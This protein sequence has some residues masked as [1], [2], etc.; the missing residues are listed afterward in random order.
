MKRIYLDNAGTTATDKEILLQMKKYW[1]SD[2]GN[3]SSMYRSG[4]TASKVLGEARARVAKCLN[5]KAEEIIF[6]GGGTE[7]DNLA[8]L[9]VARA[10]SEFGKHIIISAI[11]HKAVLSSAELLKKEGFE[12]SVVGVDSFGIV[13]VAEVLKMIKKDTILISIMLGN[14]EIGS[15][16]PIE[17]LGKKIKEKKNKSGFPIFH[18]DACQAPVSMKIDVAKLGVG[19]L[20]LNSSKIYGPK[21]AGVLYKKNDIKLQP[22]V[23]GGGQENG[24]RSGT[25]NLP[26]I[27]GMSLALEKVQKNCTKEYSRLKKMREY[28]VKNLKTSIPEII[29]NGHP[30]KVL[31]HIVHVT[32]PKIEGESMLL[33]LDQKGIEVS[34]GSAC[35]AHD[36]YPSHVMVAIGQKTELLHGSI[37]FSFG[38]DT[39]KKDLDFV[40]SVFPKIVE[41]LKNISCI[42]EKK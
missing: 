21:G 4:R 39:T 10:N 18:T 23:V 17:E 2:Y 15:I 7:S 14:N 11:E 9:G 24:F 31:P 35:A 37:R 28:F 32:V 26:V 8:I 12:V 1:G 13:S 16:Q 3:P 38:K 25:E 20:T 27:V 33:M 42:Y 29:I 40:L 30:E 19:L 41:K 34:T 36:L 5:A 22:I 6:T